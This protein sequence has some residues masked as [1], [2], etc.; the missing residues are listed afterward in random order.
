MLGG[1]GMLLMMFL[2]VADV[3][4][5]EAGRGGIGGAL[6]VTTLVMV[7]AVFFGL[8]EAERN[9]THVRTPV[10]TSRISTRHADIGRLIVHA[11]LTGV[12]VGTVWFTGQ[13]ALEAMQRGEVTPGVMRVPVWPVRWIITLGLAGLTIEVARR[14]G[15]AAKGL[16][17][18][19]NDPAVADVPGRSDVGGG[20]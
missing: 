18:P 4:L 14:V 7:G 9:S 2:A 19:A 12:L 1:L 13:R 8:A 16:W 10:I 11:V 17:P 3:L 5:R 20:L 6:D 15:Q